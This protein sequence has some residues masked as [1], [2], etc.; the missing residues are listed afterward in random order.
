MISRIAMYRFVKIIAAIA[1]IVCVLAIFIAPSIDLP[2]INL[3]SRQLNAAML[4]SMNTLLLIALLA[5]GSLLSGSRVL[6]PACARSVRSSSQLT[7]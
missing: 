2:D 1:V 3:R 6:R 7:C 5:V 4:Q